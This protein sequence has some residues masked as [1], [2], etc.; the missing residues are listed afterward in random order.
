[1]PSVSSVT[2]VITKRSVPKDLAGIAGIEAGFQPPSSSACRLLITGDPGSGK[3]T[4]LNSNPGLFMLDE[5]AGGKTVA[6]PQALRYTAPATVPDAERDRAYIQMVDAIVARKLAG[7]TDITMIGI[8][9]YD[10]MVNTFQLALALRNDVADVGDVGGGHGKGYALVREAIFGMLKKAYRAGLG[11]AVI[12]HS[13]VKTVTVGRE[14][15]Q[16]SSLAVSDSYKAAIFR[17]CE[18]FLFV[19]RGVELVARPPLVQIVKGQ[20]I[21]K[22]QDPETVA[23]RFLKTAPG[24]V[25]SGSEA[26]ELKVRVPLPDKIRLPQTGGYGV[27]TEA[28]D[29]AVAQLIGAK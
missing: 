20:K 23:G 18:H 14:E 26:K 8:D 3:S 1:M 13:V 15:R 12:A 22:E 11:W 7:A 27:F 6:D 16:I 10:A 5:E 21:T 17:E 2:S 9:S 28:Y 24:G 29:N 25:W 19:E 4:F